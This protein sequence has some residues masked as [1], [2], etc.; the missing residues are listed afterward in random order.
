[1]PS[2]L[3]SRCWPMSSKWWA[4]RPW[5]SWPGSATLDNFGLL[6]RVD[7]GV[8]VD[9]RG[10]LKVVRGRRRGR[11]P[12]QPRRAPGVAAGLLG[13]LERPEEVDQREEVADAEDGRARGGH[14]VE[15]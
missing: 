7:V 1:M 9:H 4:T 2:A 15:H 11:A 8:E 10:H 6:P 5:W 13:V 14:D 3:A 12:L